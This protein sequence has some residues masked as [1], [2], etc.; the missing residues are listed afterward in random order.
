MQDHNEFM[1]RLFRD[2]TPDTKLSV[3]ML[4]SLRE[5]YTDECDL[6]SSSQDRRVNLDPDFKCDLVDPVERDDL[7]F[8]GSR[9][10]STVEEFNTVRA[11]FEEW[12]RDRVLKTLDDWG[13]WSEYRA[14]AQASQMGVRRSSGGVVDQARR[15]FLRA[16]VRGLW[17]LPGGDYKGIAE[18]LTAAGYPTSEND[19]KNAKRAKDPVERAIPADA[20][21]VA[22]FVRTIQDRFPK[23]AWRLLVDGETAQS[24]ADNANLKTGLSPFKEDK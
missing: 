15:V 1:L 13:M 12:R 7:L 19:L 2:R 6:V 23:F 22:D 4:T 11:L 14:G 3:Q 10:W 24:S 9:P 16:Y 20:P 5:I 8:C 17:G 21:G 18:W